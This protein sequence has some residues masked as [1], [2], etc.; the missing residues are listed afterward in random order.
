[1]TN[2][3]YTYEEMVALRERCALAA[4]LHFDD[5]CNQNGLNPR[6]EYIQKWLAS[7]KIR[8]VSI[9]TEECMPQHNSKCPVCKSTFTSGIS[10][11]YV[12][13]NYNCPM[14][15]TITC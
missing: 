10:Y 1:M 6:D 14:F 2:R 8:K 4:W 9:E 7:N 11:G 3:L 15:G 12:C 13:Q 5:V